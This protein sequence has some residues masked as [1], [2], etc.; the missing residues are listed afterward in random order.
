MGVLLVYLVLFEW[1]FLVVAH[2]V[3]RV[4]ASPSATLRHTL[5]EV[6]RRIKAV[7]DLH[8]FSTLLHTDD[9]GSSVSCR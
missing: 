3:E 1:E 9:F 6:L 5:D 2:G 7:I 8:G 4:P